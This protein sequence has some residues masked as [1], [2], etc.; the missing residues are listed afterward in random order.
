MKSRK[1]LL[2]LLSLSVLMI[3]AWSLLAQVQQT[4]N[5]RINRTL[6]KTERGA[7]EKVEKVNLTATSYALSGPYAH[8]NLTI[9]LV[10]GEDRMTGKVPLTLQEAMAQKKVVVH[11][12]GD[13]NE[14][15]IENKSNEDVYVQS[16][17]IVKGGKQDRV[18]A[19]DLLVSPKSG[20]LPLESFCVEQSRWTKRGNED[21]AGFSL[22]ANS[23]NS[24][25]LKIAAKKSRSQGEVWNKVAKSQAKMSEGM[26]AMGKPPAASLVRNAGGGQVGVGGADSVSGTVNVSAGARDEAE[27]RSRA[28]ATPALASAVSPSSL[29]LT[30][31]NQ[32]LK[33]TANEYIS[34]LSSALEGKSDV[35]GYVFAINGQ[36][37]SADVYASSG[38]F[39]KLWPKLLEASAT[40]A[41]AE[42]KAEAS[43]ALLNNEAVT[44]FL[45]E[46]QAG[47]AEALH[48]TR[49]VQL[50][51]RETDKNLFFETRDKN[52]GNVWVHRNYITK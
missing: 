29:Q 2:G 8:R 3:S 51:R 47:E 33:K 10:H 27:R 48:V 18:L 22:S 23:V 5:L 42:Y 43:S 37:N 7:N 21:T 36:L 31:E 1:I 14:L 15:A 17:D 13:V 24:K 19:M 4:N 26:V 12:T 41:I 9:W 50:V 38:L 52:R 32:E 16:G 46:A 11:E 28:S 40:E 30:L 6:T 25:E 49:R 39:K 45:N 44:A 34:K 35:I 20:R